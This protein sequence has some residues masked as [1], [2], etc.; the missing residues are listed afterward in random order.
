[1]VVTLIVIRI[2][3]I[4]IIIIAIIIAIAWEIDQTIF[5]LL[6]KIKILVYFFE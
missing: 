2:N 5:V 6:K 1:M 3:F 4:I